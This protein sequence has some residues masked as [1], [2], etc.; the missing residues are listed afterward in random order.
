MKLK[1]EPFDCFRRYQMMAGRHTGRN[2]KV[3]HSDGGGEY[4]SD[5]F[6]TYL[7]DHRIEHKRTVPYSLHQNGVA[8]RLNRTL[9]ELVWSVL[10][11]KSVPSEF[12]ADAVSVAVYIRNRVTSKALSFESD[13]I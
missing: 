2:V 7:A 13:L 6:Q 5:E 8:E 9:D 1:S 3:L 11:H 10:H 4:M 12:W